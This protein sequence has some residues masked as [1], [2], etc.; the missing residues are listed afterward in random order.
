M[1]MPYVIMPPSGQDPA[2]EWIK[3]GIAAHSTGNLPQ[4][5]Q[6]YQQALRVDPNNAIATQN[7]AVVFAQSNLVNEAFLTIERATLFDEKLGVAYMNWALM[8]LL[9]DQID[10]ALDKAKLGIAA[11]PNAQ[12][13]MALALIL[14]TAGMP[15][16]GVEAYREVLKENPEDATAA[17]N[18][19]FSQSL[20]TATP[21]ELLE[22]R[23]YWH[24]HHGYKGVKF[25]HLNLKDAGRP[26]RVGYVSGDFK[27]HSA[28][29]IFKPAVLMKNDGI[30]PYFYSTL[31]VNETT[32]GQTKE[33]KEFAGDRWRDIAALTDEQA[34]A[35]IRQDQIDVLVDLAGH[36]NG[37][38]LTLF[39][40]K[41]A[42]V[43]V[44]AWGFAHGTGC[45]EIDYFFADPVAIPQEER[46]FYAEQIYD[47][48]CVVSFA[49]PPYQLKGTSQLP[50]FKNEYITFGTYARY[51]KM[52]DE[53]L[54]VFRDIL[55]QV[56]DSRLIFKD[57]G[58]RRPYS[59]KRIRRLMPDIQPERLVF[60][61]ATTHPEHMQCYQQA[62]LILD[63]YPHSGGVVCLEQL[64]MGVPIVTRYGTQA[65]GRTSSSV[66]TAMGKTDWIAK[67]REEYVAKAVAMANDITM[68]NRVRKTLRDEF[69]RSPV[70]NGYA[71]K[72][73]DAYRE[74]WRRYC[75][76]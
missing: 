67:S 74:I 20:T 70:V 3:L 40:R 55:L 66:L 53:C 72:V 59:I 49:P 76:S 42:P 4:A 38:R 24:A 17:M 44:T 68:L 54:G 58:I 15:D 39:T 47:L 12:T 36:T 65:S 33:F 71:E 48:P 27:T 30:V 29:M 10:I 62:D 63:P 34:E 45:P 23:Q 8:A 64:Y 57:H 51:E 5:Q 11:T 69:M 31:P 41:P 56:S 9:N 1:S 21:K 37:G 46:Q 19:C 73:A 18:A 22:Q 13:K 14:S 25:P 28:A 52:N 2:D 75:A 6:H 60:S 26:I 32:D 7:L 16:Q 43:Q 50:Y 35:L 61:I